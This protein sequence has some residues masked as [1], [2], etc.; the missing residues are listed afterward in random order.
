MPN[1]ALEVVE[2]VGIAERARIGIE[3]GAHVGLEAP[4]LVLVADVG[5]DLVAGDV[6]PVTG[7]EDVAEV[8]VGGPQADVELVERDL[9][10]ALQ[11]GPLLRLGEAAEAIVAGQRGV[12]GDRGAV[13]GAVL[14]FIA[15]AS[16]ADEG[17]YRQH[18]GQCKRARCAPYVV[19]DGLP[20]C[21]ASPNSTRVREPRKPPA[22]RRHSTPNFGCAR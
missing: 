18:C 6:L 3:D 21:C 14:G 19:H 4:E 1:I 9:E 5:V 12:G 16:G 20:Q 10:A 8:H 15:G 17:R 11:R 13:A 2:V 22:N 7:V